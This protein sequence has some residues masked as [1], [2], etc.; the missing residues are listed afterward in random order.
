MKLEKK[1]KH[2]FF[3]LK[4]KLFDQNGTIRMKRKHSGQNLN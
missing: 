2:I 4:K 1:K 3:F